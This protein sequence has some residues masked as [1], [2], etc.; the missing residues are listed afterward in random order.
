MK[1]IFFGTPLFSAEIL[2]DLIQ[3][4]V[5]VKAVVTQPDKVQGRH[6]RSQFSAVKQIAQE[7]LPC[8]PLYQPKKVKDKAFIDEVKKIAVDFY[9]VVAFGQIFPKELLLLPPHGCINVHTS[10]LPKFRGAAPIQRAIIEGE[11][12]TG[13]SIMYMVEACDAG[14]VLAVKKVPI[15]PD[16]T[17]GDLTLKL[18]AAAKEL[19]LPTLEDTLQKKIKPVSQDHENITFAKKVTVQTAQIIWSNSAKKIYDLFRGVSPKPGAWCWVQI[20]GKRYRIKIKK[21]SLSTAKS[22]APGEI[23]QYND[24]GILVSCANGAVFLKMLQL[25]GKKALG[26]EAFIKGYSKEDISF[27]S[28]EDIFKC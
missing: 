14:D 12:E 27:C 28:V 2:K 11:T 23:L 16:I 10:L 20:R 24:D 15:H 7:L 25:E 8:V 19:L 22:R 3:Q 21:M 5:E 6:L 13:V 9:V 18:C 17:A 4:G 1:I 26:A